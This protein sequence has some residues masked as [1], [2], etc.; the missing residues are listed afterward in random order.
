MPYAPR[1]YDDCESLVEHYEEEWGN[2]YHYK[3]TPI[4][5][6]YA[7]KPRMPH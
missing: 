1:S 2:F 3:I 7:P 6:F 5:D 4:N